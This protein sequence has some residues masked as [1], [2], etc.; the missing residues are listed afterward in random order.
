MIVH[1][2]PI[3]QLIGLHLIVLISIEPPLHWIKR[4]NTV[5]ALSLTF[6]SQTLCIKWIVVVEH[7]DIRLQYC[8]ERA[9]KEMLR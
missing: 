4:R 9:N 2:N 1:S 6:I 7:S 8:G 5:R 3:G